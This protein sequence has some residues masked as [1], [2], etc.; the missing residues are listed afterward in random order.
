ME[1]IL[2]EHNQRAYEAAVEMMEATGRAAVIHPTGTGKSFIAFKLC[3]DHEKE[4]ICWLS[5]SEYIFATQ[6]EKWRQAG[7]KTLENIEFFTYAKLMRR[8]EK[9]DGEE[10]LKQKPSFIILDEFHRLGAAQWGGGVEW[11]RSKYPQAKVLGLSAT[12]IRYL[13]NQRDMAWELFGGNI[14]SE[15][16]LG[17]AIAGGILPAPKYVLSVYS[18]Q[19]ELERYQARIKRTKNRAV[20]EKA[21]E[22]LQAL[23]RALGKA[24]GLKEVFARHMLPGGEKLDGNGRN[25]DGENYSSERGTN[26]CVIKKSALGEGFDFKKEKFG[27]KNELIQGSQMGEEGIPQGGE[28]RIGESHLE[29]AHLEESHLG[30]YIVFCAS[31]DHLN[32]M[33]GL[34]TE[35][36]CGVDPEPHIYTAYAEDPKTGQEFEA[37]KADESAHLKLLYCIDMLNEGIHVEGV[38]GVILLRP[39]VSPTIY[40]QQVGR[41]LAAGGKKTPIIFDIVMN[42]ENLCSIGAV[43]EEWKEAVYTLRGNGR[44]DKTFT[45]HFQIIDEVK[46]CRRLFAQLNETLTASWDAMYD[47][48]KEYYKTYGNLEVPAAY[49]TSDGYS[50]GAWVATQ[51]KVYLGR[52]AGCLSV[53]QIKRLE[54]IGMCWQGSQEAAWERNFLEA[55]KYFKEHGN[56]AVPADY[57]TAGGCR[58]GRWIR[59]QR[60]VYQ[61]LVEPGKYV[62]VLEDSRRTYEGRQQR[63]HLERMQRLMQIGMVLENADPWE[64]KFELA[65]RYYEDH[66]NLR[67]AADYVVEGV[68]LERWLREQKMRMEEEADS[69]ENNI[70]SDGKS[71]SPLTK[72]QRDKLLSIGIRPGVSQAELSWREQYS[73]AEE[74]YYRYGNLDIPKRYRAE[75]GK[76]L[77]VWLQHQRTNRRNGRLAGWQVC[78][79]DGIGMV[80]ESPDAWEVGFTHAEEYVQ[81]TGNLEVPNAYVCADGYRLGKWISNQRC[82]YGGVTK[83]GLGEERVYRLEEIGMVWNVGQGRRMGV[84]RTGKRK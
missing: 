65:R 37:F 40:K 11:L 18:Y 8:K 36:F 81:Q 67:M 19:K 45:G 43:E 34:A 5:P 75:N 46:D 16:T 51:R 21:Q 38:D 66:G 30:K 83:K 1:N 62:M 9:G 59:R 33:K 80:W 17:A 79:L 7:G 60:E 84:C 14:A 78:L 44:E 4:S 56:L 58:L 3:A 70:A 76:N 23:R 48:A 68:W 6:E 24:D 55:E 72:G 39:T 71:R 49:T 32:E 69:G 27:S 52:T 74:F 41:A 25:G 29:K 15:L 63:V 28:A 82:A 53:E 50:L 13:D 77:G 22:E 10:L 47:I 73:E 12:N 57:V 64:Q 35:W 61:K 20:R 42:I 26:G 2:F 31:F 54:E